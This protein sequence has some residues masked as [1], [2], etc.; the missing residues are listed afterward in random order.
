[1][2]YLLL[3]FSWFYGL[4]M[5]CR[6]L[7][8]DLGLLKSEEVGVPV[9]S[10]GNMTMGGTGKTPLVEYIVGVCLARGRRVAVVTRGYKRES[11]GVVVVS[12]GQQMLVNAGQGGDEPVQIAR[13][14]RKA[15][16]VVGEHRIDAARKAVHELKS[17][18]VVLDDGFQHRY[19]R[20]DLDIVVLDARKNLF[21]LPVVPAGEKREWVSGLRR[22]SLI[23]F[24][25]GDEAPVDGGWSQRLRIEYP[26]PTI[27][28]R[29]KL[30][31]IVQ[32][33]SDRELSAADLKGKKMLLLSGIGDHQGFV[34]QMR[35]AGI[36]VLD[37]MKFPDHHTYTRAN[38]RQ[39]TDR[40]N[41]KGADGVLTTEKDFIRL[42]G[43]MAVFDECARYILFFYARIV[44]EIL[45]GR[46]ILDSMIDRCL[47]GRGP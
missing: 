8:F 28:Y 20:R 27:S 34:R 5:G 17:D 32:A 4:V 23:A 24:S 14:F 22:A 12:D 21:A 36:D 11:N 30:D 26:L 47:E 1:M 46:E 2:R 16:V 9:I 37:D 19:L 39:V 7:A 33:D 29:Y 3:P 45:E 31:R 13:K 43:D 41:E 25:R 42:S 38:L 40:V 35:K 6:N 44:V 15:I 18:V 10:V